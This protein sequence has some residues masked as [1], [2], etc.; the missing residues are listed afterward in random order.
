MRR[1]LGKLRLPPSPFPC[2]G[3]RSGY[4]RRGMKTEKQRKRKITQALTGRI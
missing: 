2:G 1:G 3:V 4:S